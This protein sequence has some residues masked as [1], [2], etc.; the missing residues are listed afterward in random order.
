MASIFPRLYSKH[1]NL[2]LYGFIG[3]IGASIDFVLYLLLVRFTPIPPAL[4]SFLSVS[5]GIV[6]NFILNNR[7]NFKTTDK[8]LHRFLSFYLV[9]V[10]G[11]ILSS[12]LIFILY[13]KLGADPM[14]AKVLTIPPVVLLQF[15]INKKVSFSENPERFLRFP[16]KRV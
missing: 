9:G 2:V 12:A 11:A 3:A 8:T 6:N 13:N 10:F 14:L 4:A 15:F 1:R 7:H 5:A 16:S